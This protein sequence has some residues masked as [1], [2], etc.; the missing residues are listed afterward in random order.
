MSATCK[1]LIA[2]FF[3]LAAIAVW[4]GETLVPDLNNMEGWTLRSVKI[5][6]E[7]GGKYLKLETGKDVVIALMS[8]SVNTLEGVKQVKV[9]LKYRSDME[10][11]ALHKGAWYALAFVIGDGKSKYEGL[12]LPAKAEWTAIEKTF[13]VPAEA[14][15]L[16]LE[17]RLQIEASKFLDAK[18]IIIELIK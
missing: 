2:V 13:D 1:S 12:P 5:V 7:D 4:A 11:S 9:S 3:S 8:R 16:S 15:S 10:D 17:L 18:D 14:K 6:D